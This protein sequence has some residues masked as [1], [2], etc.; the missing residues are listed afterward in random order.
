MEKVVVRYAR[1]QKKNDFFFALFV[2][3]IIIIIW[4]VAPGDYAVFHR[5]TIDKITQSGGRCGDGIGINMDK[6]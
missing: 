4:N 2:I 3:G 5:H 1:E 6:L